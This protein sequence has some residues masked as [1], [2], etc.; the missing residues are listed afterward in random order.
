[1]DRNAMEGRARVQG[2]TPFLA[3]ASWLAGPFLLRFET[4]AAE[5]E[6]FFHHILPTFP[7]QCQE[8]LLTQKDKFVRFWF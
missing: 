5:I 3:A 8:V 6:V 2:E 1:M 4:T 7:L